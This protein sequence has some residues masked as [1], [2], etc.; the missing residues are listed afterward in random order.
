MI[1]ARRHMG[2]RGFTLVELLVAMAITGVVI[3]GIWQVYRAQKRTA[4][5]QGQVS[6]LQ[7]NLRV[8]VYQ[9][10]RDI[11]MAG[12]DPTQS[13]NFGFTFIGFRDINDN[14]NVAGNSALTIT[15]DDD[16]DGDP[17]D[18]DEDGVVDATE[19]I[20]YSLYDHPVGNPDN[21]TDLARNAGAGRQLLAENIAAIGIAYAH[22]MDD[23]GQWDTYLDA[24]GTAQTVWAIDSNNDGLLDRHLDVNLDGVID[25]LD[26]PTGGVG[27]PN[28]NIA[29][30]ALPV[31]VPASRIRAVRIWLLAQSRNRDEAYLD[32][33]TY[34]IGRQIITPRDNLWR[35]SQEIVIPCENM[36]LVP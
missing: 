29:G 8:A 1:L 35:R 12:Y 34:T 22:D 36:G 30:R 26:G 14:A 3:G 2:S 9:M 16:G 25:E 13:R 5:S 18:G 6:S 32:L 27:T 7:Q 11:R 24:T 15:G 23:N 33:N 28:E 4:A 20:S 21:F 10:K 19:T 31:T 17:A